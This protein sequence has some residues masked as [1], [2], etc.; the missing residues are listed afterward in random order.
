MFR[1]LK[2]WWH[3]RELERGGPYG[4]ANAALWLGNLGDQRAVIDSNDL[5][6]HILLMC[7]ALPALSL[8]GGKAPG[9]GIAPLFRRKREH[10]L[11]QAGGDVHL[12]AEL[13][14]RSCPDPRGPRMRAVGHDDVLPGQLGGY[15]AVDG[16]VE[17]HSRCLGPRQFGK[18]TIG[19]RKQTDDVERR[20]KPSDLFEGAIDE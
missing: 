11:I 15:D 3:M 8:N 20:G 9:V 4:R 16:E 18:R 2:F 12:P 5:D 10:H 1:K 13:L 17:M 7:S 6:H 14:V 19:F